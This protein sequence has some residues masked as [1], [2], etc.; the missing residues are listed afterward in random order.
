MLGIN[1]TD[2]IKNKMIEKLIVKAKC[3]LNIKKDIN[4][5]IWLSLVFGLL[6]FVLT[7]TNYQITSIPLDA[8][9]GLISV[10]PWS[11]WLAFSLVILAAL[12]C[13]FH[14]VT[15]VQYFM[16]ISS[17]IIVLWLT[18]IF[19]EPYPRVSDSYWHTSTSLSI[20]E[21]GYVNYD[22]IYS[23]SRYSYLQ[24]PGFF[25]HMALI[26]E[27]TGLVD[28]INGQMIFIHYFPIIACL[29]TAITSYVM[30]KRF[31][32][33]ERA[34][35]ATLI[36]FLSNVY[37]QFH[38][39]PQAYGLMLFPL[40]FMGI[41]SNNRKWNL[42]GI[43]TGTT[44]IVGH[45]VTALILV[46][47][48]SV[49]FIA[50]VINSRV[51]KLTEQVKVSDKFLVVGVIAFA[52]W[53]F[54]IAQSY[55]TS[56]SR[57]LMDILPIRETIIK[58]AVTTPAKT[59]NLSPPIHA[60]KHTFGG[61][62][63]IASDIR[64][65]IIL[66]LA[67]VSIYG[68]Y[69]LY[70]RRNKFSSIIIGFGGFSVLF[71]IINYL[72]HQN[73]SDRAVMVFFYGLA[74]LIPLIVLKSTREFSDKIISKN[75]LTF[76]ALI[77]IMMMATLCSLTLYYQEGSQIF[78]NEHIDGYVYAWDIA[79]PKEKIWGRFFSPMYIMN[80]K[81]EVKASRYYSNPDIIAFSKMA[82]HRY[83]WLGRGSGYLTY[84]LEIEKH[85][86]FSKV[87]QNDEF[88]VCE[89]WTK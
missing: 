22:V 48:L 77:L 47:V 35:L 73:F 8:D 34:K 68:V 84:K 86:A 9:F 3:Q 4:V 66:L 12:L 46:G 27:L 31:L 29:V 53:F 54:F 85:N 33:Y 72:T 36:L 6:I 44:L 17:L 89:E 42:M 75:R 13:V 59:I 80:P 45:P 52:G 32:G 1:I 79:S 2:P 25:I 5:V 40:A 65:V 14:K 21:Y 67:I 81:R 83:R 64:V 11:W 28:T 82:H 15:E 16:C 7:V 18:P 70:K 56:L 43:I 26:M 19:I 24:F 49:A 50:S 61:G 37:M 30:F 63:S 38:V 51:F 58:S 23:T 39:S 10:L 69:E 55:F 88:E 41:L 71:Y 62:A 60:S 20:L 57:V 74:F 87:Y 78:N 76:L